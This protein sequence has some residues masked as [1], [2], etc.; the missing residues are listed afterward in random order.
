M[1]LGIGANRSADGTGVGDLEPLVFAALGRDDVHLTWFVSSPGA[2]A[3]TS[4]LALDALGRPVAFAKLARDPLARRSL[5]REHETLRAISVGTPLEG[6]VPRPLGWSSYDRAAV[7]V[8][9]AAPRRAGPRVF[10]AVHAAF[11]A[12]L[13]G[14]SSR[15]LPFDETRAARLATDLAAGRGP[16]L[17]PRWRSRLEMANDDLTRQLDGASLPTYLAH[18]DFAP[19][20]TRVGRPGLFVFD[21]EFARQGLLPNHDYFHFQFMTRSLLGGG[22][23]PLDA[24]SWL[25]RARLADA[26]NPSFLLAYLIDLAMHYLGLFEAEGRVGDDA[27]LMQAARL[28]DDRSA[29]AASGPTLR[30]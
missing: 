29:W 2:L 22:V 25:R 18:R 12:Q 15:T 16:A 23:R 19:W 8:T 24:A 1:R 21:W 26:R 3:K 5:E 9:T 7:M 27:T 28:L 20:N 13:A 14:W 11:Q 17:T 30:R 10:G 4:V 6:R